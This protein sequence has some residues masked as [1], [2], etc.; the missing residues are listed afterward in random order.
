MLKKCSIRLKEVLLDNHLYLL[1]SIIIAQQCSSIVFKFG[2]KRIKYLKLIDNLYD[3]INFIS[4]DTMVEFFTF[5]SN[6]STIENF[7][8]EF[9]SSDDL[10]P[11]CHLQ[12]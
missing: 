9:L 4:F 3:E 10:T 12:V 2:A 5:L 7:H 8:H 1:L 11:G 6:L